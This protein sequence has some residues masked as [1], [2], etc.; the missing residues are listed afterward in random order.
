MMRK[1]AQRR[2]SRASA[3]GLFVARA[4]SA[5]ERGALEESNVESVMEICR[6]L[7]GIP[8]AIELAA[9]RVRGWHQRRS[10][11][12]SANGSGC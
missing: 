2:L 4:T 9:A 12:G 7:D 5:S 10:L 3:V 11:D 1:R 6:Q 8:L